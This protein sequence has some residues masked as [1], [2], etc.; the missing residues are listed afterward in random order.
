M[1]IEAARQAGVL[2]K[3]SFFSK[4]N[5]NVKWKIKHEP[6]TDIDEMSNELILNLLIL[7][8]PDHLILSEELERIEL[9][10]DKYIWIIDPLDGTN[11]FIARIPCF[12]V[13]IAL[14]RGSEILLAVTYDPLNDEMFVAEK[15]H[16]STLNGELIKVSDRT[17]IERGMLLAGRGYTEEEKDRHRKIIYELEM[18]TTWFR[19]LGSAALMLAYVAA[20]RADATLLTGDK[21]WDTAAGVLLVREAGGFVTDYCGEKWSI[22]G[23]DTVATN[24]IIHKELVGVTKK[25]LCS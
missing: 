4:K 24:G 7:N 10:D 3:N 11:N 13:S 8:F 17:L 22:T 14:C 15:G 19:R 2:L 6:V 16:G 5:R 21:P 25:T 1:A 18:R 12:A 9:E 23:D 20:G